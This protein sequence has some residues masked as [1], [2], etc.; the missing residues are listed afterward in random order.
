MQCSGDLENSSSYIPLSEMCTL[1]HRQ[2]Y[3][4]TPVSELFWSLPNL[5]QL[6]QQLE[7][8]LSELT[9]MKIQFRPDDGFFLEAS[10]LV[11][12]TA[13]Q[14][15]IQRVVQSLNEAVIDQTVP[16]HVQAIKRRKLFLKY[17]I[18]QDRQRVMPPPRDTHGRHRFSRPSAHVYNM[19][20]PDKNSW[21]DYQRQLDQ[22]REHCAR[23][24][25][26]DIYF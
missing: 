23:P 4:R 8:R 26:F 18:Y 22:Q 21:H 12:A 7:H 9:A 11:D 13:N 16:V 24:S 14:P 1:Y 3:R 10:N 5:Q 25:L 2:Q 15:D 17:Y 20:N 6:V 19:E